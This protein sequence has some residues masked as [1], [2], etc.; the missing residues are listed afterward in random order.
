MRVIDG[1]A[2][3]AGYYPEQQ[4]GGQEVED[5]RTGCVHSRKVNYTRMREQ[6]ACHDY[7]TQMYGYRAEIES[8]GGVV[9]LD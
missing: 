9:W 6:Q 5:E 3:H 1:S 8:R 7:W 2:R 4:H